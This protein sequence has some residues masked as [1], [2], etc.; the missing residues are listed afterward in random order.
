MFSASRMGQA[1]WENPPL[2]C[3]HPVHW[4]AAS[5]LAG[6][7]ARSGNDRIPTLVY[8][9]ALGMGAGRQM[10]GLGRGEGTGNLHFNRHP[11]WFSHL[12]QPQSHLL[13]AWLAAKVMQCFL[14][15]SK[16]TN[17]DLLFTIFK[18]IMPHCLTF[19]CL[20]VLLSV[21]KRPS[22]CEFPNM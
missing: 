1:A 12:L 11:R 21:F 5:E 3:G 6:V 7:I 15:S 19:V 8:R 2:L 16:Q 14:K 4:P 20:F 9:L 18:K 10:K 17:K 13:Q 22:L